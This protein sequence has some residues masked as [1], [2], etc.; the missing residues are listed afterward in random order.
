M[1]TTLLETSDT[2]KK[3][4]ISIKD[5]EKTRITLAKF[6]WKKDKEDFEIEEENLIISCDD[7]FKALQGYPANI[8]DDEDLQNYT[9]L[10]IK[11]FE[12]FERT[13]ALFYKMKSD[14]DEVHEKRNFTESYPASLLIL[15]A[16]K[17]LFD[18]VI[19][20]TQISKFDNYLEIKNKELAQ[21]LQ[22]ENTSV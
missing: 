21:T 20:F 13:L 5:S 19:H 15:D 22:S 9:N 3:I 7:L 17:D 8:F 2:Q 18:G 4:G 6:L 12:S 10:A 14:A 11:P 1:E 16:L